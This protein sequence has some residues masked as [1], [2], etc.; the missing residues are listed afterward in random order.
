MAGYDCLWWCGQLSPTCYCFRSPLLSG[1]TTN[2]RID[3]HGPMPAFLC[4][5]F[6]PLS[7]PL[8]LFAGMHS[9]S[10]PE[11]RPTVALKEDSWGYT[12][13]SSHQSTKPFLQLLGEP[14]SYMDS[15]I[16][17]S[18]WG[19]PGWPQNPFFAHAHLLSAQS[20]VLDWLPHCSGNSVYQVYSWPHCFIWN[21]GFFLLWILWFCNSAQHFN[22]IA[23]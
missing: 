23:Q 2:G 13:A 15:H 10:P 4:L 6:L 14:S 5:Q 3:L 22:H 7:L 8:S 19:F 1:V 12:K 9:C 17:C 11:P 18:L 20:T 21:L 16:S